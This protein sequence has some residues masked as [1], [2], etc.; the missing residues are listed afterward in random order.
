[1]NTVLTILM[2]VGSTA[3]GAATVAFLVSDGDAAAQQKVARFFRWKY[4]LVAFGC[5]VAALI[6]AASR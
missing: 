1:M 3:V 2:A 4:A 6:L 5:F